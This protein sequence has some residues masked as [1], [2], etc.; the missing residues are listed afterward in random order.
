MS[1]IISEPVLP[2][3]TFF[4][5]SSSKGHDFMVAGGF[6]VAGHRID[7]INRDIEALRQS[8]SIREFHWSEYKG[9]D[10]RPA[11]EGLARLAF[12]LVR[13]GHATFHV[14]IC[15]FKGYRHKA[16]PG[17]NRD[18]SVNRMYFQLLLHRPA[19]F[20]GKT[21]AIHVRLDAGNDSDDICELRNELCA[22]AYH[23]YKTRANCVRSIQALPS[24]Q[25]PIIQ[26]ADVLLGGI[27]AKRNGVKHTT[28]KGPLAD[29]ILTESGHPSWDQDT[30]K[31][32]RK[33]T[34]WNFNGYK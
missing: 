12:Q 7:Q 3:V 25:S 29:L 26:M 4:G 17:E 34:V 20:H 28:E 23:R 22:K 2:S 27:A 19:A 13:D 15:P 10:Q 24:N 21:R 14:I 30:R 18:T 1:I 32:A 31:S 16:K 11:Y 5:D 9:G 8:C 6:A 33:L